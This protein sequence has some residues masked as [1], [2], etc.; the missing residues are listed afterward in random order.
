MTHRSLSVL[1]AVAL[2]LAT[3]AAL[4]SQDPDEG[5]YDDQ[6]AEIAERVPAFCGV[7][8]DE[9]AGELMICLTDGGES[10]AAARAEVLELVEEDPEIAELTPVAVR[11]RYGWLELMGWYY[12]MTGS[13][14]HSIASISTTDIDEMRNRIVIGIVDIADEP[15]VRRELEAA[16]IPAEA[17]IVEEQALVVA[18][19]PHQAGAPLLFIGGPAL[20]L[21]LA[22]GFW[23]WRRR[24]SVP[25]RVGEG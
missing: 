15:E 3:G 17:V 10:L 13:D 5:T 16:G 12:A 23:L 1:V 19:P 14:V 22:G 7:W 2:Q 9:E 25:E 8:V 6:L 11:G 20:L 21:T 18:L 24:R 4:A